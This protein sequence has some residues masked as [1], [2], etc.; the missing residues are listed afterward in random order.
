[1]RRNRI[2]AIII[3]AGYSSR[4]DS[5]KPLLK[6]KDMTAIERLIQSYKCSGI[7]EIYVIVGYKSEDIL[8]K[9][10]SLEI[11]IV[12]NEAYDEGMFT[13]VKKGIL[14]LDKDID[15]F[16]MQPVDIPLIK[17]TTLQLLINSFV[18]SNKGVVYP[19]FCE[20]KGHPPLIDCK[21]NSTILNSDGNGGLK[22]IL[23]EFK[24]DSFYVPVFDKAILMDMDKKEDY[25]KLLEYDNRNAP[26]KE[27]CLAIMK[28]YQIDDHI[29]RH[30]EA[31]EGVARKIYSEISSKGVYL[32][33]NALFAAA[34]LH[35]I[36]RKEKNHAIVGGKLISELGYSFVGNIIESHIDIEVREDD[37]ITEKEI[38]YLADKL[39]KEDMICNI[40]DR[41]EQLLKDNEDSLEAIE[42]I[43][44]RWLSTK[45]IIKKIARINLMGLTYE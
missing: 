1:M 13:S 42:K 33:D 39:V 26:N 22:K 16:F 25:E 8:D 45:A 35:D 17:S 7:E 23:E 32:D 20:Q 3:S 9:L 40:D 34:L 44:K 31:V 11:D 30:G 5:F 24:E 43:K 36:A 41:F 10:K 27:E 18:T 21:Y 4:M 14:A 15:A 38:L 29:I 28:H 6:F 37:P 19:T 12:F 2:A